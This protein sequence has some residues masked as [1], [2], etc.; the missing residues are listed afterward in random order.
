MY[1]HLFA[2]VLQEFKDLQDL[3]VRKAREDPEES[4]VLLEA[5]VVLERGYAPKYNYYNFH[6]IIVYVVVLK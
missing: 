3:L 1:V 5:V 6:N 2:R 4:L